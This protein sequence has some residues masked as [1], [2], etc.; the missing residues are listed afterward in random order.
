MLKAC[1]HVN[2]IVFLGEKRKNLLRAITTTSQLFVQHKKT[3]IF[4][5]KKNLASSVD[6]IYKPP[7]NIAHAIF[8]YSM[9]LYF[10][11]SI[12]FIFL[13][14]QHLLPCGCK[15]HP[16]SVQLKKRKERNCKE[17]DGILDSYVDT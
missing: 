8:L 10:C 2:V 12:C 15:L 17:M 14:L 13:S 1:M 4:L 11:F 7:L 5:L 16:A 9:F 3:S 6:C